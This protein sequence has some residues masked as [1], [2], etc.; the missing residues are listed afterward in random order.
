MKN[1]MKMNEQAKLNMIN[2]QP[3]IKVPDNNW[4]PFDQSKGYRQKR[5]PIKKYVLCQMRSNHPGIPDPI[6]LGYRKD[7]AGDKSCPYFV[8][9]GAVGHGEVYRWCDC[10]SDHFKCPTDGE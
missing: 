2:Y 8:T 3:F 7:A 6:V 5:P 4:Y 10:L 9:P 1:T